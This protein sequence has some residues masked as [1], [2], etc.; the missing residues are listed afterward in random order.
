MSMCAVINMLKYITVSL[1]ILYI[2][3]LIRLSWLQNVSFEGLYKLINL[4]I[5]ERQ[6]EF[7]RDKVSMKLT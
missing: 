2:L 4:S 1:I 5:I 6:F 7:L 3:I